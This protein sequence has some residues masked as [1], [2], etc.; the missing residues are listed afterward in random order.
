MKIVDVPLLMATIAQDLFQPTTAVCCN[1]VPENNGD[2]VLFYTT[3]QGIATKP[4][5]SDYYSGT[6]Y[7]AVSNQ[8][9][10]IGFRNMATALGLFDFE[11]RQFD[12]PFN[13]NQVV[14]FKV[15]KPD[16]LPIPF[17]RNESGNIEHITSFTVTLSVSDKQ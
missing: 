6:V 4:D 9:Y 7:L 3:G 12:N 8:S 10:D 5:F 17:P 16:Q 1:Q 11:G 14:D 13:A 15:C 2:Y